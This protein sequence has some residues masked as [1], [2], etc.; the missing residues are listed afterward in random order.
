MIGLVAGRD[1]TPDG[2]ID[3]ANV[4]AGDPCPVCGTA[5]EAARGVEIGHI[6]QLGRRYAEALDLKVLNADGKEVTVTMGS[7]G[8]GVSRAVAAIAELTH[9]D[10]GLC[11]PRQVAPADVHV[12]IAGKPGGEQWPVA[13]Q[14]AADLEAAGLRVLLDD[15][16]SVSPGVKF[17]DAE[18]LGVP[19][20]VVVGRGVS[21]GTVEVRD[22]KSGE[23][24]EVPIAD[25]VIAS[26]ANVSRAMQSGRASIIGERR[27]PE[28]CSLPGC[29]QSRRPLRR[30]R[31]PLPVDVAQTSQAARSAGR[32]S[33]S[34]VIEN[35]A[36]CGPGVAPL[37]SAASSLPNQAAN[38][39]PWA[40]PSPTQICGYVRAADRPRSR[41]PR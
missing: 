16:D 31:P 36:R 26:S 14:L 35:G 28:C 3:V 34:R 2:V 22:R 17:K 24:G 21:N 11:W 29:H 15:R 25:A 19:T 41:G 4:D 9:D 23:R 13:E 1:F 39:K 40:A 18:L 7:Y 8:I 27:E 37:A 20:I 5:L 30:H 6:F 12:V 10:L 32:R 33:A 38:L